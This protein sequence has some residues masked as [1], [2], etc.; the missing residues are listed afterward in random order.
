MYQKSLLFSALI[1]LGATLDDP[2][3]AKVLDYQSERTSVGH[4]FFRFESSDGIIRE[5]E[6]TLLDENNPE[7]PV[8]VKG[9]Y[10]YPDPTGK[11]YTVR[12]IADE[13]GF[14]PE[15]PTPVNSPVLITGPRPQ[16]QF[17]PST[18]RPRIRP[19]ITTPTRIQIPIESTTQKTYSDLDDNKLQE[20]IV[21]LLSNGR[22]F[23]AN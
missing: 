14:H 15:V 10:S 2:R 23:A 11:L 8:I 6:G 13:N 9:S 7:S 16:V 18:P 22:G 3:L 21:G 17:I 1:T 5:E 20:S 4:Y 19:E 12:Y